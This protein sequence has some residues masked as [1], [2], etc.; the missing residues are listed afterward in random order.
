MTGLS[1]IPRH[2]NCPSK[3][4]MSLKQPCSEARA[5]KARTVKAR[6]GVHQSLY[7]KKQQQCNMILNGKGS[8]DWE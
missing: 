2:H 1:N 3:E 4:K 5:D 7:S 8:S 6:Y